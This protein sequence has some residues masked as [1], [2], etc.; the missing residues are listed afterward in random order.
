M[1]NKVKEQM[2]AIGKAIKNQRI[3]KERRQ[4]EL[5]QS[6]GVSIP[7]IGYVEKATHAAKIDNILM[8]CNEL[9][10]SIEV[11]EDSIEL[12]RQQIKEGK[13]HTPKQARTK[14]QIK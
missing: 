4:V 12:A 11:K 10:L 3:K 8:V 1:D 5:A 6:I 13:V 14:L 9:G 2:Q 7:V